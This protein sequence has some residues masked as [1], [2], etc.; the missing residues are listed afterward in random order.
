MAAI[1]IT[2]G[3][4][5]ILCTEKNIYAAPKG[6]AVRRLHLGG[7][8]R[9]LGLRQEVQQ[10]APGKEAPGILEDRYPWGASGAISFATLPQTFWPYK[11]FLKPI[12]KIWLWFRADC[13]L[14]AES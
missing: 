14:T 12:I 7:S 9:S 1:N 8:C 13:S 4:K 6:R 10:A 3:H 2:P 5:Y 11:Y